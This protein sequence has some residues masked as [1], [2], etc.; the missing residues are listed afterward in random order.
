MHLEVF[1][2]EYEQ[3]KIN[4]EKIAQATT[5]NEL[6]KKKLERKISLIRDDNPLTKQKEK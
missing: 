4:K 5:A 3:I 1:K 2:Y 6:K